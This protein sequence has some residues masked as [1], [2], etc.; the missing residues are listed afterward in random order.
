[1]GMRAETGA[2]SS[3]DLHKGKII[4]KTIGNI[5]P[6]GICGSALIDA[7]TVF[8]KLNLIGLFGEIYSGESKISIDENIYLTQKDINEFQLAKSALATGMTILLQNLSISKDQ[9]KEV[10]IAGGF[11]NYINLENVTEIGMINHPPE[12]IRRMGNTALIGAKMFLFEDIELVEEI[13]DKTK[14]INLEG[15][16]NFQDIFV[17]NLLI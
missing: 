3:I 13:L 7:V 5:K 8:R 6:K 17:D 15:N 10:Y 2:I 12:K 16:P 1:M 4:T 14:H 11:G 9:I